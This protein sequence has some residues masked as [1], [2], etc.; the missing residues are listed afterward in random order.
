M[1]YVSSCVGGVSQAAE[2]LV[3]SQAVS[4]A[5][6]PMDEPGGQQAPATSAPPL[7]VNVTPGFY[8]IGLSN[9][10][11]DKDRNIQLLKERACFDIPVVYS[12]NRR[13][14]LRRWTRACPA[15]APS[16]MHSRRGSSKKLP[17]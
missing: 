12:N 16:P 1:T 7:A 10:A 3:N 14:I 11:A 9:M 15:S 2:S 6:Q 13:A 8:L 5:S 4:D 17:S